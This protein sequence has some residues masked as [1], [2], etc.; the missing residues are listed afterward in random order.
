MPLKDKV[1]IVTGGNSGIGQ[2]IVLEFARLH[3]S[4]VIDY[5]CHPEATE[6]LERQICQLG[7]QAIGVKADVSQIAELQMLID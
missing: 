6:A 1:A 5:V 3:A 2:A 7:D 4:V